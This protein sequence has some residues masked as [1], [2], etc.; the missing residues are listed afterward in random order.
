MRVMR[1]RARGGVNDRLGLRMAAA[2]AVVF[3]GR[4]GRAA[5]NAIVTPTMPPLPLPPV[6]RLLLLQ[7]P[8]HCDGL[9]VYRIPTGRPT[10][11]RQSSVCGK[12]AADRPAGSARLGSTTV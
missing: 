11:L 12:A 8:R 7:V 1:S 9:M 6:A 4:A 2:L 10:P 5:T 3:R